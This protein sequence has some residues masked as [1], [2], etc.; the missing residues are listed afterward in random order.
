MDLSEI[1]MEQ[2][3]IFISAII[4]L[5]NRELIAVVLGST[6]SCKLVEATLTMAMAERKLEKMTGILLHTD[7]GPQFTS[8]QH[9][10]QSKA[11]EFIPSMSRRAN[12]WDNTVMES[13]FSHYKTEFE[14]HYPMNDYSYVK[15]D[16]LLFRLYFNEE[17]SQKSSGIRHPKPSWKRIYSIEIRVSGCPKKGRQ[18]T[19][20]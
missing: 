15:I 6:P 19:G 13:V 17:R 20:T 12:C 10:K 16:L 1:K 14:L 5:F 7:Q 11:L 8:Y 2:E 18:T 9:H 4:D 3:K